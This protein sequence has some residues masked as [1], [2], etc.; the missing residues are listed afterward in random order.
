MISTLEPIAAPAYVVLEPKFCENCARPFCR[1]SGSRTIFCNPC[2]AMY[3]ER[4]SQ[5]WG[6]V[7]CGTERKW[8]D[9][10]PGETR[11]K[12]LRCDKCSRVTEHAFSR[13]SAP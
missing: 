11:G 8:G 10:R 4:D 6:C 3:F 2:R 7:E 5:L 9:A 13:I 1:R 12:M